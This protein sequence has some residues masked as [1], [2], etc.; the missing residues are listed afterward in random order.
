MSDFG[1]TLEGFKRKRLDLLLQEL[2]DEMKNIFGANFNVS[3]ESPDG[4]VNGTISE[5]NAN[6]WEIAEDINTAFNPSSSTGNSLSNLVQ[7]NGITRLLATGSI[8]VLTITGTQGT[9]VV[10]GSLVST[11]DTKVQFSTDAEVTIPVSGSIT[12]LATAS[13][14]GPIVA[15]A[16]TITVIDSPITGWVSVTNVADAILGRDLETDAELRARR[17][18]SV[19]RDA[20]AIVDAVFAEVSAVS[21]VT[22]VKVLENDTDTGPDTNGLPAHSMQAIV[23]GGSDADIAQAIFIKKTLGAT[24]FGTT[25]VPVTD[26]QGIPHDISFSR[27]TTIPIFVIVNLTTF[28]GYPV[29]GDAQ[30][31]QAIIDYANGLLVS[32][33]GFSLGDDV[34]HSELYTPINSIPGHTVDSLF[35]KISS[36][37]DQTADIAISLTEISQ[38]LTA[39]ITVNS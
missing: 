21:G 28:A 23:V 13:V 26:D 37:A 24:P 15:L 19:A 29:D 27:P 3:P 39:N 9:L 1:L 36:P 4:Q 8:V 32:T 35:I 17:E 25:T 14:T 18:G 33:R 6:L 31:Q 20:Q 22:N 12:V 10:E 34:I 2:N 11:S 30:I 7:F 5:S 38:F 16:G